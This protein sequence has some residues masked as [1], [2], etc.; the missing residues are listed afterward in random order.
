[1]KLILIILLVILCGAVGFG[2]SSTYKQHK[3]FFQTYLE[4]L[5]M[6]KTEIGFSANKLN[7]ILSFAIENIRNKDFVI[8]LKNYQKVINGQEELKQELLFKNIKILNEKEKYEIYIFF[9]SLGK[10]DVFNQV[11]II[12][13]KIES[14]KIYYQKLKNECDKYCPLYTKL[15]ILAG[16]FLALI[17]V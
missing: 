8:L 2:V 1:M 14:V 11:E 4:F 7:D 13:S 12:N 15:G 3:I 16:L 10:T 9:K 17:I 5:E 6:L